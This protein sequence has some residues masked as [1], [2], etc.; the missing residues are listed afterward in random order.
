MNLKTAM[1]CIIFRKAK[2]T[3]IE[4]R[5]KEKPEQTYDLLHKVSS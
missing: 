3:K 1:K 4:S 5:G 2:I